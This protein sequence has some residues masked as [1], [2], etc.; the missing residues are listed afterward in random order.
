VGPRMRACSAEGATSVEY[1]IIASLIAVVI[2]LVVMGLGLATRGSF[3]CSAE[4]YDAAT[5]GIVD[6]EC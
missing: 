4:T 3:E 5:E 6:H 1:A 2:V